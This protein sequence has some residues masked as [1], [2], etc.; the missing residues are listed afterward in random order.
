MTRPAKLVPAILVAAALSSCGREGTP[1]G[2]SGP[3]SFLTGTWRGTVTIQV[4][5]GDP[6]PPAPMSGD[7]TWT[8]EVVPPD[9]HAVFGRDDP[10]DASMAHDGDDRIDGAL[11]GQQSAHAD[12]HPR[13]VQLTARM[14]R[15]FRECRDRGGDPDRGGLHRDGL[16]AGYIRRPC[17]ADEGIGFARC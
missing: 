11:S 15:H 16:S 7:M 1:T 17:R 5:P 4:N 8:F 6:N 3:T 2:P 14:S 12:Q 10:L 13:R 9:E